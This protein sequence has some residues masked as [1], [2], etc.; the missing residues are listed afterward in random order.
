MRP[1]LLRGGCG[2]AL[3]QGGERKKADGEAGYRVGREM[4]TAVDGGDG[5]GERVEGDD[6]A[7]ALAI[8]HGDEQSPGAG[9]GGGDVGAGKHARMDAV[10]AEDRQ[11]ETA[12]DRHDVREISAGEDRA[13]R[14]RWEVREKRVRAESAGEVGEPE[15]VETVAAVIGEQNSQRNGR[16]GI[17]HHVA[18]LQVRGEQ[19]AGAFDRGAEMR[20]V[21]QPAVPP[22]PGVL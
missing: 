5:D 10:I 2:A 16:D 11:I 22:D 13:R 6:R 20:G 4:V 18:N 21:E 1:K 15:S 17:D 3:S 9:K 12:E 7:V 8:R 14:V 19:R